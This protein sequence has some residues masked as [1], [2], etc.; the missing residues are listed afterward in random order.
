MLDSFGVVMDPAVILTLVGVFISLATLAV[1]IPPAIAAMR[2]L[3]WHTPPDKS[4][5]LK[6]PSEPLC[7]EP[8]VETERVLLQLANE[9]EAVLGTI[10]Y[11]LRAFENRLPTFYRND[12]D[13]LNGLIRNPSYIRWSASSIFRTSKIG[14]FVQLILAAAAFFLRDLFSTPQLVVTELAVVGTAIYLLFTALIARRAL[15]VVRSYYNFLDLNRI[16]IGVELT[17]E[18]GAHE[19]WKR[20][21]RQTNAVSI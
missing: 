2:D 16:T 3:G 18:R 13:P 14:F 20:N 15:S 10:E 11:H 7:N 17:Q 4:S 5:N 8:R 19:T 6:T 1:A 9:K 21:A 12:R